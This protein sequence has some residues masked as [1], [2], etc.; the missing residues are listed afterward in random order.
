MS[1]VTTGIGL[2][3]GLKTAELVDALI[4]AQ[5]AA[6]R[7]LESRAAGFQ[8]TQTALKTLEANLFSV[9]AAIQQLG[10]ASRFNSFNVQNSQPEQLA[11]TAGTAATPGTYRF[12]AVRL[13]STHEVHSRGFANAAQQAVGSGT[14]VIADGGFLNR[15]TL[16]DALN[17]GEGI[18]RGVIRIT[19]RAGSTAEIDLSNVQTVDDVLAA[20]NASQTIAVTASARDGHL[21]L[22]DTSGGAGSLSV[23]DLNGGHAAEDLGLAGTA[24]GDTLTGQTVFEITS[25]FTFN[26]LNDGNGLRTIS[27]AP[28]LRVTLSD[29]TVLDVNLDGAATLGDVIDRINEH[30]DNGGK[31]SATLAG[32]RLELADLSGGGGAGNFTVENINDASVVGELGLDT[33]A[34][35]G[36]I[37]GRRLAA[38]LNSVLLRNL[39]GGAGIDQTGQITLTDRTG[40]TATID[41][42][43]AESL[44]EVL[45]AINGATDGGT[46][47]QLLAEINPQGTGIAVRDTSGASASNLV[48]SD[49]GGSTL[50]AQLGIEVDAAVDSIDS[51][52]LG[53]RSLNAASSV[54]D[55]AP[56]GGGIAAGSI[57]ITDSAGNSATVAISTAVTNIGDVLQRL[58][59]ASGISVRAELNETGDGFVLIDEAGGAG[60]LDVAEVGG[61]TAADLRLLGEAIA[62]GDGTQRITSRRAAIVEVESGDTLDD[63]VAKINASAGFVSASVLNTGS[64]IN[65]VRLRLVSSASGAPAGWRSIPADSTWGWRP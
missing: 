54:A 45:A 46:K 55:Y 19:D 18:R 40:A 24:A 6:V 62:G 56:D 48:I 28:A 53:L 4:N 37:T 58:N 1:R 39:H 36:T 34:A 38:G 51:G 3:S 35:G 30:E 29:D 5:R 57:R 49:L 23:A 20:I 59:A 42:S 47:L 61:T 16:I 32:G 33:A 8:T 17:G 9:K 2:I 44:D 21:V 11:V 12:Q 22:T 64:A 15:P 50:A 52:P 60:T 13:A 26:L 7:R 31:L 27:G 63:V 14:L 65:P 25:D 10:E 43:G 41:L